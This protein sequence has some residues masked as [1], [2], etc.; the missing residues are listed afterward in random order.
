MII[1]KIHPSTFSTFAGNPSFVNQQNVKARTVRKEKKRNA[2]DQDIPAQLNQR[3]TE[4]M[5]LQNRI[6]ELVQSADNPR[7]AWANWMGTMFPLIHDDLQ[8][9]NLR[10]YFDSLSQ[11]NPSQTEYG[12]EE[13]KVQTQQVYHQISNELLE[14][15][16][17]IYG[18]FQAINVKKK[19]TADWPTTTTADTINSTVVLEL[20]SNQLISKHIT[21]RNSC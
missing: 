14:V 4:T 10:Q 17:Q 5:T 15:H 7:T 20:L 13:K 12:D 1:K 21:V 18:G 2:R 3:V 11:Y 8:E 9:T 19:P 6:D 16:Q